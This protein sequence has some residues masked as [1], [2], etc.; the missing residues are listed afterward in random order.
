MSET[1]WRDGD[2][3]SWRYRE[4]PKDWTGAYWCCTRIAIAVS[5]SV[6]RDIFWAHIDGHSVRFHGG[7][8]WWERDE[9]R[10]R[11]VLEFK[12][13]LDEFDAIADFN[14]PM[15]NSAD[16][17]D[18]RHSNSSQKQVYLRK[19]AKR[20]QAT[21]LIEV[22]YRLEKAEGEIRSAQWQIERLSKEKAK[23]EAGELDGVYL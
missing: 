9:A 3:F 10:D 2:V 5:D 17:L 16:I 18:L 4:E 13:N 22:N 12:G 14:L 15:Y 20:S 1:E 6:I 11:L 21:M 7:F 23:I 19:G 8:R